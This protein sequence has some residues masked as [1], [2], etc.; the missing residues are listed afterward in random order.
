M[1]IFQ[2]STSPELTGGSPEE[3]FVQIACLKEIESGSR[4]VNCSAVARR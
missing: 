1:S 4:D 3:G 2:Y